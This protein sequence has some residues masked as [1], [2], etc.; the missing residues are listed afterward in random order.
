[1]ALANEG[2]T[3]LTGVDYSEEG[4]ALARKISKDRKH[5]ITFKIADLLSEESIKELG[6]FKVCHDKG[7]YDAISLM[8]NAKEMREEYKKSVSSLMTD[9]G[10]F[11]V[12]SCNFTGYE[13]VQSFKGTFDDHAC[14]PT[15][16]FSF[17]GKSGSVVTSM[18]FKKHL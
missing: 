11:I 4:I 15:P 9:D 14:I 5:N 1:M 12:T 7:T 10:L 16:V 13:M 3:N 18:I 8:A 17:G 2:Y 6:T